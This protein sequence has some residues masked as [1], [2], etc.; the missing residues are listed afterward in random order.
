MKSEYLLTHIFYPHRTSGIRKDELPSNLIFHY[1]SKSLEK[2]P[3]PIISN[4]HVSYFYLK[5]YLHLSLYLLSYFW[6]GKCFKETL[7]RKSSSTFS[8]QI[9]SISLP[10]KELSKIYGRGRQ[11]TDKNIIRCKCFEWGIKCSTNT[12]LEYLTL[13]AFQQQ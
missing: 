5:A 8:T 11:V 13:S 2:N 10:F 1:F 6:I 12:N 4:K 9:F 7:Y 3:V